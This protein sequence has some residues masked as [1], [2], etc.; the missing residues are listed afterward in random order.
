MRTAL[1][2]CLRAAALAA[3]LQA[4][5]VH[6]AEPP[7][8]SLPPPVA[9]PGV[10]SLSVTGEYSTGDYG[11][12]SSTDIWYFPATLR[13]ETERAAFRVTVPLM[14]YEGSGNVV[15]TPGDHNSMGHGMTTTTTTGSQTDSGLG[16]VIVS[17][18]YV[19]IQESAQTPA[20]ALTGKAKLATADTPLLGTGENDYA[21]ELELI[22]DYHSVIGYGGVGYKI[23]GDPPGVDFNNVLY[24][25]VG[26]E[27][28]FDKVRSGGLVLDFAQASTDAGSDFRQ[29]T[30]YL[31]RRLDKT[32]TARGY[33]L[34]GLS[35]SAPDWGIGIGAIY[36]W[37]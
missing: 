11:T 18:T 13:Y 19:V 33:L 16:D 10:W 2:I 35:D 31:V 25:F 32:L 36:Y 9:A 5:Q 8:K 3:A 22:K 34:L 7:G 14:S 6:A 1:G 27:Y 37:R 29:L 21:A 28:A 24:G 26:A 30:G 15:V 4:M 17:A 23:L 12:S 20:V